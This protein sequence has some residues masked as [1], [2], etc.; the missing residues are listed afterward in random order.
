M[1]ATGAKNRE[2]HKFS[3]V[4]SVYQF[5]GLFA[6]PYAS[7]AIDWQCSKR[8]WRQR[9]RRRR[10][11]WLLSISF[12]LLSTVA[13][14]LPMYRMLLFDAS[15][16][17][18]TRPSRMGNTPRC[19]RGF[20]HWLAIRTQQIFIRTN[21]FFSII[22]VNDIVVPLPPVQNWLSYA[23]IV[24]ASN[25]YNQHIHFSVLDAENLQTLFLNRVISYFYVLTTGQKSGHCLE[26]YIFISPKFS[27]TFFGHHSHI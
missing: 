24:F 5:V 22:T 21:N 9:K 26:D 12:S 10:C 15:M 13:F 19:N 14:Y 6:R 25:R 23:R 17:N 11:K 18:A 20:C 7:S 16:T 4:N 3:R 8:V 1:L 27:H 2:S